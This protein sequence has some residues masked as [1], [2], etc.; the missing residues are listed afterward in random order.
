M[1]Q[2]LL[3]PVCAMAGDVNITADKIV[4][5][6]DGI[7]T[8]TGKVEIYR[9]DEVMT[10]DKVRYDA[11][12]KRI[13]AEGNVHIISNQADIHAASGDMSTEDKTGELLD[14]EIL[15][16]D[17]ELITATRLLRISEFTYQAFD[18]VMTSCPKDE[19]TW[20]LYASEGM[21]D[22]AE[23]I[24]TAKHAR[25]AFAGV[26][27]FYSPYWQQAIRRKSGFMMPSFYTGKRR[28][29]EWVLP[30][31]FAPRPNW[32]ATIAPHWMTAR[33]MMTETELRHASTIGKEQ[34][35][36]EGLHDKVL[37][38]SV[39]RLRG[40]GNW[41]LPLDLTLSAKGDE[42]NERN[43]LA[44]FSHDSKDVALRYLTSNVTLSQGFEYGNWSLAGIYNHNLS[45]LNNKTTL[46]QYPNFNINLNVPLFESPATL[47]YI[48]NVTRFSDSNGTNTIRD[49]RSYSHPYVTIPWDMLGGGLSS[50]LTAGT[51]YTRYWLNQGAT[52]NPSLNS[53]EFSLDSQMVF[54]RINNARTLR[55]SVIPR[56][57]YDFNAVSNRPGVPNFDSGLSPLRLSNLFSG[58]RYSGMDNVERSNRV[59]FLL[60]NNLETKDSPTEAAWTVL[61]ISGGVQ[62]NI[63]S[64][65]NA[66]DAPTGFSNL[67]GLIQLSPTENITATVEAEYDP[68]RTVWNRISENLSLSD[69]DGDLLSASYVVTKTELATTYETFQARGEYVIGER[70]KINGYINY[71]VKQKT[72]QQ[73]ALGLTYTHPCWD[74]SIETH[75]NKR[76]TATSSKRD[77]GASLLIGFK[78]LG[79][80]GSSAQ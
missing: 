33:G 70:W 55:H 66:L 48:Q 67:L 28:G 24:F 9:N 72:T 26:P 47:H 2:L 65:F 49:W 52:R 5:D 21:L 61:S 7:A 59:S 42:V 6:T 75:S 32:D 58:N 51:T 78:G 54:E 1:I 69:A 20:H 53:G 64:R 8:A 79:S 27:V 41:Q 13:K 16:P 10:A 63:R 23:G 76:P 19:E 4:R 45:T 30:Y 73:Q 57:R 68:T 17:G 62:Y 36:F 35:Q 3:L 60:T 46:Q 74:I 34:I 31:Y 56:I 43:Y 40:E 25:F 22:Q 39:G 11:A 80:V 71:D 44:E 12:G 18:P 37:G 50:T 15:L 29:T 77:V 14:A 38:R